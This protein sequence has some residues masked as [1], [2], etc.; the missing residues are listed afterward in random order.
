MQA[1]KNI[2]FNGGFV[3]LMMALL[4]NSV[5]AFAASTPEQLESFKKPL[6]KFELPPIEGFIEGSDLYEKDFP[7]FEALG[8]SIRLPKNWSQSGEA[9]TD[10]TLDTQVMNQVARYFSPAR[11]THARS[12]AM[13]R[14]ASLPFEVSAEQWILQYVIDQGYALQGVE[15][16]GDDEAE[17]LY[18]LI[19][20]DVTLIT[21]AKVFLNAGRVIFLEYSLPIESWEAEKIKQKQSVDSFSLTNTVTQFVEDMQAYQFLDIAQIQYPASWDLRAPPV[22]S[23]DR[24]HVKILN[25]AE[26][27]DESERVYLNGRMTVDLVS[28]FASKPI[29]EEL[30]NIRAQQRSEGLELQESEDVFW[31]ITYDDQINFGHTEVARASGTENKLIGYEYWTSVLSGGNY[32][33]FVT[34]LTPSREQDFTLWSRNTQ[35]YKLLLELIEPSEDSLVVQ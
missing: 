6:P 35:T 8:Y 13:V 5:V 22:R 31:D 17:A 29:R 11:G 14:T 4:L 7:E 19:E 20:R 3:V 25:L 23:I 32:Y 1:Q 2:R 18:V 12:R 27:L 15:A 28:K 16:N 9:G 33:Y 10:F 30:E 24:I 34:L 21:R 26:N